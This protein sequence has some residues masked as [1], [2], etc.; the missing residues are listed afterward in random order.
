MHDVRASQHLSVTALDHMWQ[1]GRS[2]LTVACGRGNARTVSTL[3]QRKDLDVN[4]VDKVHSAQSDRVLLMVLLLYL[5]TP[6]RTGN[7]SFRQ[8]H[9]E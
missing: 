6:E 4:A 1:R 5:L 2:L 7:V 3:L 9:S 8:H